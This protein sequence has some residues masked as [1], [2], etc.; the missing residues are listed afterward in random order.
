MEY[1]RE[2]IGSI[3]VALE[4]NLA[5]ENIFL[6]SKLG[7]TFRYIFILHFCI[8]LANYKYL[9]EKRGKGDFSLRLYLRLRVTEI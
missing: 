6:I 5:K 7:K 9:S 8:V 2:L 1:G 4:G 3:L